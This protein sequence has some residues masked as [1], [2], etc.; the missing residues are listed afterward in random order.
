MCHILHQIT[1]VLVAIGDLRA[2][3]FP[4]V[5][6]DIVYYWL[7]HSL[8]GRWLMMDVLTMMTLVTLVKDGHVDHDDLG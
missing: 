1:S 3:E 2:Y 5:A 8:S 6:L 7:H 4:K